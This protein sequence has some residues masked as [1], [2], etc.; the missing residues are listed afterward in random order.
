MTD[1]TKTD[2]ITKDEFCDRFVKRQVGAAQRFLQREDGEDIEAVRQHAEETA[3]SYWDD[4]EQREDGPEEC[5][6]T[7]MSYWEDDSNE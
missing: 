3:R 6:D 7:D 2:A 1:D 4:E 5:A